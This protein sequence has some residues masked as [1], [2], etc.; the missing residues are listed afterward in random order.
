MSVRSSCSDQASCCDP[1]DAMAEQ[2]AAKRAR[3]EIEV[4]SFANVDLEKFTMKNN[5]KGANGHRAF[6]LVGDEPIRFNLTPDD[7]LKTVFGFDITTKFEKPSFL[8]GKEPENGAPEGLALRVNLQKTQAEFLSKL[9]GKSQEGFTEIVKNTWSALV[10]E[11]SLFG[12]SSAKVTVVLKGAGLT[13]IAVVADGKVVRG[14]GW[15]FL[16]AYI[17]AGNTFRH[18]EIKLV[19]RVKKLW[20]VSGKA[21]LKLEATQIVLRATDKPQEADAFADDAELLA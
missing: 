3:V 9:D 12:T 21:G 16:K 7:W 4:P 6:P 10:S 5:G 19:A 8:G 11:D 13:K 14:E 17:D 15:E 2:S 18:A 20:H 1:A